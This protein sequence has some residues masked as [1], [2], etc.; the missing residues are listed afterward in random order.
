M[1]EAP[2][3]TSFFYCL[4]TPLRSCLPIS[5]TSKIVYISVHLPE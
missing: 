1:M 4:L 3:M 5:V 2:P